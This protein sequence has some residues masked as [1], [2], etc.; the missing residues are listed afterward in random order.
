MLV[1]ELGIPNSVTT[2]GSSAFANCIGLTRIIIGN[3]VKR[4]D[5]SA[6]WKC[7]GLKNITIGK[8]VESI[9]EYCF[10]YCSSLTSVTIPSSLKS[11]GNLAFSGCNNLDEVH[12]SDIGTW[13]RIKNKHSA[14]NP[15]FYADHLYLNDVEITDLV[16]PNSVTEMES[17][18]FFGIGGLKSVIIP[19]SVTDIVNGAFD[20]CSGLRTVYIGSDVKDVGNASFSNCPE[21]TDF[22]CFAENVPNTQTD[23]FNGSYIDLATLHVPSSAVESYKAT[24]PWSSFKNIVA[25]DGSLPPTPPVPPTP[26]TPKCSTPTITYE[27]GELTFSC[28]TEGVEYMSEVTVTDAKKYYTDK[29]MLSTTYKVSV[30]AM[31]TGY[32]NSDVATTEINVG[33]SGG[34]PIGDLSGDGKVNAVDLTKMIEILLKRS[35]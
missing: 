5:G 3:S 6:F 4:I 11:I 20:G 22:Y 1:T 16:I 29:V 10:I 7:S 14:S 31:K 21:L 27:N 26:E 12:I 13:S 15:F 25:T 2:I 19:N 33:G 30:Y 24:A 8:S 34:G 17:F 18:A 35:N 28:A 23:A 32:D 9:G